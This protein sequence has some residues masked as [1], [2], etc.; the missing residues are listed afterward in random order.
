MCYNA[1]IAIILEL[2]KWREVI[3]IASF[4]LHHI[5]SIFEL[6]ELFL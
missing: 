4:E 6:N 1:K 3:F 2:C 5:Y